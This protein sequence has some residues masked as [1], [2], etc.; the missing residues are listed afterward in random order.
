V[1]AGTFVV[2]RDKVMHTTC[3]LVS[4]GISIHAGSEGV[5]LMGG[6]VDTG[7]GP[8]YAKPATLFAS[9]YSL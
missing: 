6:S 5:P 2:F 4:A 8:M 3:T 7:N 9:R 1:S